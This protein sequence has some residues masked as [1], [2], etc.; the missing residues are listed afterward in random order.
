MHFFISA[1]PCP[2]GSPPVKAIRSSN[3]RNDHMRRDYGRIINRF[4]MWCDKRGLAVHQI[5]PGL[6]GEYMA[7]VKGSEPTKN[8]ALA[9]LRKFFDVLVQ[10]HAVA[11]NP[12]YSITR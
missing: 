9:A 12:L 10:R 8:Q 11:L 5:T 3:R 7:G 1:S 4:L 2:S 6:A